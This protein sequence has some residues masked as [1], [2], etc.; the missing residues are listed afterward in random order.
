MILNIGQDCSLLVLLADKYINNII[1]CF[2]TG[3]FINQV[4]NI[5]FSIFGINS[6][7]R[8]SESTYSFKAVLLPTRKKNIFHELNRK[9][10]LSYMDTLWHSSDTYD[11]LRVHYS[12]L[13][14]FCCLFSGQ[15]VRLIDFSSKHFCCIAPTFSCL[16]PSIVLGKGLRHFQNNTIKTIKE[17]LNY[18]ITVTKQ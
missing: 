14:K 13:I 11:F 1:W 8:E 2:W 7:V 6:L 15:H 16:F 3:V 10:F 18:A 4:L 12:C 5:T 9:I 17:V